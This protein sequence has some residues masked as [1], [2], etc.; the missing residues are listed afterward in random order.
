MFLYS[1][2]TYGSVYVLSFLAFTTGYFNQILPVIEKRFQMTSKDLGII[3]AANDIPG[4]VLISFVN[5]FGEHGNKIKWLGYGG[6]ITGKNIHKN[7]GQIISKQE[8]M[9]GQRGKLLVMGL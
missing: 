9:R 4:L 5:Y 1:Y 2:E 8:N 3:A 6:R 7:L